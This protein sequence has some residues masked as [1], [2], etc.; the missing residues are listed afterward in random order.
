M[1]R[2]ALTIR[3]LIFCLFF[4]AGAFAVVLAILAKPDLSEYYDNRAALIETHARNEHIK[5]LTD[6]YA[7]RIALIEAN[8][9]ILNRFSATAFGRKPTAPDTVFPD[10]GSTQLRAET[11]RILK[12][13]TEPPAGDPLPEWLSRVMAHPTRPALFLAGAALIMVAFVFFGSPRTAPNSQ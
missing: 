8:P 9:A 13:Q 3:F 6:Q 10:P 5:A 7:G 2:L 4:L 12:A 1:Q 11:E